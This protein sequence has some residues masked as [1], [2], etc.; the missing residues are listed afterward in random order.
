[1]DNDR[2]LPP[3]IFRLEIRRR[4]AEAPI[5]P[6]YI[7]WSG[8]GAQLYILL[9]R[10]VDES[11]EK[12]KPIYD[13]LCDIYGAD[14]GAA[15]YRLYMRRVPYSWNAKR[16]KDGTY[17]YGGPRLVEIEKL[18]TVRYSPEFLRSKIKQYRYYVN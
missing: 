12:L 17:K 13:E 8:G 14:R 11:Q 16:N 6:S 4:I 3:D 1:M 15:Y 5:K 9:D 18:E 2:N 7:V 10:L